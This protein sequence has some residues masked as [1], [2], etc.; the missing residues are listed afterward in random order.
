[1]IVYEVRL[2]VENSILSEFKTWL[3]EHIQDMLELPGFENCQIFEELEE[4]KPSESSQK[5][6]L[7][8]HYYMSSQND[9]KNY[10]EKYAKQMRQ[11]GLDLFG[12]QFS[13][14]RTIWSRS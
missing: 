10:F 3:K 7:C 5:T 8:C 11:E 12:N 4:W 2:T 6:T 13:A 14:K 9:L 1:M